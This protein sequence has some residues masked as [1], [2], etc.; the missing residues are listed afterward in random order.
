MTAQSIGQVAQANSCFRGKV[1]EACERDAAT[2]LEDLETHG[3]ARKKKTD[4]L[5]PG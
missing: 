4:T 2:L 5:L 1:V 3:Y